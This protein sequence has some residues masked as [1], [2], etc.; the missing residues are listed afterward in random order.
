MLKGDDLA[1][2]TIRIYFVLGDLSITSRKNLTLFLRVRLKSLLFYLL[3]IMAFMVVF[4]VAMINGHCQSIH[5][6]E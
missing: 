1:D 2:K 4:S 5:I 6:L 3:G